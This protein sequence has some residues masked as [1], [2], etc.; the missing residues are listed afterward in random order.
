MCMNMYIILK[1][2]QTKVL[3][4]SKIINSYFL[5]STWPCEF[6]PDSLWLNHSILNKLSLLQIVVMEIDVQTA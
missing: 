2:M 5:V 3:N 6:D 1:I 4:L